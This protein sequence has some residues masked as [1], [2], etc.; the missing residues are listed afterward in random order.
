MRR[1][2]LFAAFLLLLGLTTATA[3]SFDVQAEDITSFSQPVSISVPDE[4]PKKL[5]LNADRAL[6]GA[7]L[8][9]LQTEQFV[10]K[11]QDWSVAVPKGFPVAGKTVTLSI[12]INGGSGT[13][14]GELFECVDTTTAECSLVRYG[15][16][17]IT[18][19]GGFKSVLLDQVPSTPPDADAIRPGRVMRLRI[20]STSGNWQ[21]QYD[22]INPDRDSNIERSP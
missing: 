22:K 19:A 21:M 12:Y 18:N 2:L 6:S 10:V 1:V 9:T 5:Y 17:S 4:A 8:G 20:I 16:A 13:V 14:R 15:T 7:V 3:A 11:A